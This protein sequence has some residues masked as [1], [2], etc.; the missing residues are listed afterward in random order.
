MKNFSGLLPDLRP[1]MDSGE[2]SDGLDSHSR[3]AQVYAAFLEG[4]LKSASGRSPD[5]AGGSPVLQT[6]FFKHALRAEK[7]ACLI[8]RSP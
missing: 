5:G 1:G 2:L 6:V 8:W 3:L 7:P 4:W